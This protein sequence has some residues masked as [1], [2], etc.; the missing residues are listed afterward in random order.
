VSAEPDRAGLWTARLSRGRLLKRSA[1]AVALVGTGARPGRV[2][3]AL[4]V[5]G[6][7]NTRVS[8]DSFAY[9]AEPHVAANPRD[10]MNLLG[11]C[12]AGSGSRW[13]IATYAS[14]DGGASWTSDGALLRSTGGRDPTVV[15][16]SDGRGFVCANTGAVSV[17]RTRDGGKT[18]DAPVAVT[19]DQADHPWL[20]ADGVTGALY[21]VW[22]FDR[23]TKLGFSR[24]SDAGASFEQPRTIAE[25]AGRVLAAP[26][27]VAG[28]DGLVCVIFGVWPTQPKPGKNR[29][30]PQ[31]IAPIRVVCST[32]HG[33]G[34]GDQVDLGLGAMETS[35]PGNAGGVGLPAVAA[36]SRR[37]TLHAVFV[38]RPS[39]ARYSIIELRSSSDRGR[40]WSR[41]HRVTPAR[42]NVFY[43]QPQIA[44]SPE[45]GRVAVSAFVLADGR[46]GV[47]LGTSA[48]EPLRFRLR[49]VSAPPFDPRR[50]GLPGG[51]KH[52]AWW[53]GDY[54]GLAGTPA[55]LH[56]FWND[57]RTGRLQ[58]FTAKLP[59]S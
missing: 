15:F 29:R 56:P 23:N 48:P 28:K 40:T 38:S 36:D 37:G 10:P 42:R 1:A 53:I 45:N 50:G 3:E 17:W 31:I 22:S 43:L 41:V 59:W 9:H 47:V 26:G 6:P 55:S 8:R 7:A 57:G 18:F 27:L 58:L 24:S 4:S 46:I 21:A 33:A 5:P 30:R 39:G 34:F 52:G 25:A 2:L 12:I 20:A 51:A 19:G 44:V 11:A 14:F 16:D 32:D 35:V 54:Q 49:R 13:E